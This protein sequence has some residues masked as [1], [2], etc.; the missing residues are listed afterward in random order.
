MQQE[1]VR[2]VQSQGGANHPFKFKD[3]IEESSWFGS[4]TSRVKK[5][6]NYL[7]ELQ[8]ATFSHRNKAN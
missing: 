8:N 6:N 1:N 2:Q 3:L 4:I 7:W 5:N